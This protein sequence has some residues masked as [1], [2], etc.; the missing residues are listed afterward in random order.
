M[1]RQLLFFHRNATRVMI[2]LQLYIIPVRMSIII[3]VF[4]FTRDVIE[5]RTGY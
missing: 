3:Y 1:S 2:K 4:I 5:Y